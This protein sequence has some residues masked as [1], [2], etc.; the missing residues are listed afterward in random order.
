[1]G[2]L[3]G[4]GPALREL[5]RGHH[6]RGATRRHDVALLP[7]LDALPRIAGRADTSE[8][9][10][11]HVYDRRFV[12]AEAS[13][14]GHDDLTLER[15]RAASHV[16]VSFERGGR[17]FVDELL[18]ER[19]WSRRVAA[20]LTS[21]IGVAHLVE[22]SRLLAVLPAEVV[23]AVGPGLRAWPVPIPVPTLPMW[24]A[25]HPS[26]TRDARHRYLRE[27]VAGALRGC[28]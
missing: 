7:D 22:R 12:V 25:W 19:V 8:L 5:V 28:T 15:W 13:S 2:A 21:F 10:H 14:A 23:R 18:A 26:Q 4:G 27:I 16:I 6:R 20:S 3:S 24:L 1:M 17:G 9:V 11:Q